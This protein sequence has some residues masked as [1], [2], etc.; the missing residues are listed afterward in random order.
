MKTNNNFCCKLKK[1]YKI[2]ISVCLNANL[3]FR[4][5]ARSD[6]LVQIFI[7]TLVAK[8]IHL[9]NFESMTILQRKRAHL[10]FLRF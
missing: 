3:D 5:V 4:S 8:N 9:G 7:T 2:N 6:H 10:G 1:H